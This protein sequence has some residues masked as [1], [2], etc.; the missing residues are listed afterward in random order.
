MEVAEIVD[1]VPLE[2]HW[3]RLTFA[4]GCVQDVDVSALKGGV[5]SA[6]HDDPSVFKQ[7]VVNVESGTIEWPGGVDLD[8]DV[9]YGSRNPADGEP[10]PRRLVRP[11]QRVRT[12]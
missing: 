3:L 4:D 7:V 8:P 10:Y 5:F 9:L 2:R 11:S 1:V 6:I 12:A